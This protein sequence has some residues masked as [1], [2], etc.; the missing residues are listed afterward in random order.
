MSMV[1]IADD[2]TGAAEL[3][4]IAKARGWRVRLVCGAGG[5]GCCDDIATYGTAGADG[6]A[7]VVIATDTRSMTEEEAVAETRRIAERLTGADAQSANAPGLR[8]FKK[9]DSALRGHVVAELTT[10]MEGTG[11]QRAVYMPANPSKGR[12]IS[13]GTYYVDGKPIAETAFS[14]DPEF[15][16][17]TSRMVERFPEAGA[18]GIDMPD[19]TT[20]ADI[21]GIVARAGA[22]TLLAGGA[23]LFEAVL[24]KAAPPVRR[25]IVCGSTQSQPLPAGMPVAPMPRSVYDGGDDLSAWLNDALSAYQQAGTVALTIPHR[26]RTGREVAVHL[27]Q[28]TASLVQALVQARAPEELIVEG[29]ATAFAILSHLG[30]TALSVVGQL[31]PGVVCLETA[32]GMR[33]TLKPGSYPWAVQGAQFI[34]GAPATRSK[35]VLNN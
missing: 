12:I 16:A 19:A 14:Y 18:H 26:H 28:T 21:D 32:T 24:R 15:P 29:G 11:C 20:Q 9:T 6:G 30:L 8:L 25:I 31:A 17:R 34:A 3:A 27:R 1:V 23:D 5:M 10:L 35:K 13:D 22:D 33:I 2:I 4:G 7:V